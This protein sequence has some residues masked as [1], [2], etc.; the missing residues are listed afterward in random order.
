MPESL[1]RSATKTVL[2]RV[3]S[4]LLVTPLTAGFIELTTTHTFSLDTWATIY[5]AAA[6][7]AA[8]LNSV[9]YFLFERVAARVKRGYRMGAQP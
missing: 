9:Y 5:A 7:S 1:P 8:V 3:G 4:L 6:V 2:Y